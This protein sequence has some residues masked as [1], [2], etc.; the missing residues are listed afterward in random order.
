MD[1]SLL[2]KKKSVDC[3]N[4]VMR[5]TGFLDY[6]LEQFYKINTTCEGNNEYHSHTA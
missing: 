1:M 6:K 3:V 5:V 2:A 4:I